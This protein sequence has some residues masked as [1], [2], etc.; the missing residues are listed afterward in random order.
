MEIEIL[1]LDTLSEGTY[2]LVELVD[3][4]S[5]NNVAIEKTRESMKDLVISNQVVLLRKKDSLPISE[6]LVVVESIASIVEEERAS[7]IIHSVDI[8]EKGTSLL[9]KLGVGA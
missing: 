8:T 6:A 5:R 4:L 3:Y 1:I 7:N 2:S 9:T